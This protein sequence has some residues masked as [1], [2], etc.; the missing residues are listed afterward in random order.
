[1][2]YIASIIE[3]SFL[4]VPLIIRFLNKMTLCSISMDGHLRIYDLVKS[5]MFRDIPMPSPTQ[6][7]SLA[8]EPMS[9][10]IFCG[11]FDPYC[12]YLVSVRQGAILETL[13]GHE[14]P[15]HLLGYA[16]KS[17][18]LVSGSWDRS[19]K[20][21][22]PFLKGKNQET[23]NMV[24][25]LVE[26]KVTPDEKKFMVATIRNEIHIYEMED[27]RVVG[28][29]DL[30]KHIN[31]SLATPPEYLVKYFNISQVIS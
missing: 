6:L 27:A 20:L 15:V 11:G 16:H 13:S 28:L 31:S 17:Q 22:K 19:L 9:D 14:A 3:K 10:F 26:L 4:L 1:M 12:V 7:L 18:T 29:V 24:D 5:K 2:Y 23:I 30:G 8:C 25:R 21:W